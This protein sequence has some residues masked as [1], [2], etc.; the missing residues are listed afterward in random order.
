MKPRLYQFIGT[1]ASGKSTL[2]GVMASRRVLIIN[3]DSV[4][5][6]L[7]GGNYLGWRRE[8]KEVYRASMMGIAKEALLRRHS[9]VV[10]NCG[11]T[12]RRRARFIAVAREAGAEAV[13][14]RFRFD[15]PEEHARRRFE[16]D[17]RGVSLGK[18]TEIARHHFGEL[19]PPLLEEGYTAIVRSEALLATWGDRIA[20]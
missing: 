16:H 11:L 1:I 13:A 9:V 17:S 18:W 20:A 7:H 12:A 10:D 2:A 5:T 19:E 4:V 15:T 8:L 3:D 14:V 6:M